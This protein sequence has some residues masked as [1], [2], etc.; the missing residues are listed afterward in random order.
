MELL[1]KLSTAFGVSGNE[2]N[3]REII[4]EEIE[5]YVDQ[6][7]VDKMGNLVAH[8]KGKSPRIMLTAH[9]DEVGL[10]VK[11]IDERGKMSISPIGVV[12][13]ITLIGDRVHIETEKGIMH[14]IVTT[15][16]I[17]DGGYITSLP[18][19]EDIIVDTGLTK[20]ELLERGID[21]G[22]FLSLESEPYYLGSKDIISGKAFDDRIGCYILIE[23]AKRTKKLKNDTYFVFTVQ[24]EVGLYGAVTSAYVVNPDLAI[25]VDVTEANDASQNPTKFLGAGPCITIKD[26][27]AVENIPLNEALIGI[28]KKKKIPYQRDVSDLG[29]TEA[30]SIS[31]SKGGVPSTAVCVAVR[32]FHTVNYV[33]SKKDVEN[34]IKLLEEM[35]KSPPKL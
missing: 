23:L 34:A 15:R 9:M 35:L 6:V 19:T 14:G 20:K 8:R 17:N 7:S 21:V 18:K 5:P 22:T 31:V 12:E 27:E 33:A 25:V 29:T 30:T 2:K 26:A 32:N 28:A 4:K 13:S 3:V 11:A 24:E 16:E 1:E 10:M